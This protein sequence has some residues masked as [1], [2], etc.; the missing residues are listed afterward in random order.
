MEE[1]FF[2]SVDFSRKCLFNNDS[3][4]FGWVVERWKFFEIF[5]YSGWQLGRYK[6]RSLYIINKLL[7]LILYIEPR[8]RRL[9]QEYA[10]SWPISTKN[11]GVL[12]IGVMQENQS[13]WV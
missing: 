3:E 7:M 12:D 4:M 6:V 1:W 2:G 11:E 9:S 10:D 13:L 5:S 8:G